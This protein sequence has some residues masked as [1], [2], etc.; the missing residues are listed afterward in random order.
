M[1]TKILT[2]LFIIFCQCRL[3]AQTEYYYYCCNSDGNFSF[4]DMIITV[5]KT[6]AGVK[7][8]FHGNT[9]EFDSAR[10]GYYPGFFVLEAKNLSMK[11]GHISF[12]LNSNGYSFTSAPISVMTNSYQGEY[13]SGYVAWIQTS[14]YFWKEIEYS[15]EYTQDCICLN[16]TNDFGKRQFIKKDRNFVLQYQKNLLP[17]DIIKINSK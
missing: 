13:P 14:K 15:G 9:D 17:E 8:Y 5:V 16:S 2:I 4:D 12:C 7:C 10:E 3:S 6:N 1:K 11:D